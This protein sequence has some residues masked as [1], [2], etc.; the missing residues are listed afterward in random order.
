M[1]KKYKEYAI[2]CYF[3]PIFSTTEPPGEKTKILYIDNKSA[4]FHEV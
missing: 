2:F 4:R 3:L 1:L